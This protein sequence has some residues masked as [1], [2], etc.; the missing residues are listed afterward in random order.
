M[1]EPKDAAF[2]SRWGSAAMETNLDL[3][4]IHYLLCFIFIV[5]GR[6]QGIYFFSDTLIFFLF[7]HFLFF[8]FVFSTVTCILSS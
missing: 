1:G 4:V 8:F 3:S 5:F 6:G 2:A 7:T